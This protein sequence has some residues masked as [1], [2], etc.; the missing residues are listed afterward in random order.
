MTIGGSPDR[1]ALAWSARPSQRGLLLSSIPACRK[2]A[3]MT[4][5]SDRPG[6]KPTREERLAA[7]L[8][9]N[10]RRRKAQGRALGESPSG[11][12]PN[13]REGG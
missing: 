2:P 1:R 12:L 4:A 10:L 5:P 3:P 11:A 6:D 8:R 13:P 7:K 9:E